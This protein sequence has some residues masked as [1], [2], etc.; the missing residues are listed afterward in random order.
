M[1]AA[2]CDVADA[3]FDARRGVLFF[4]FSARIS[5]DARVAASLLPRVFALRVTID[6]FPYARC[7]FSA[8][9]G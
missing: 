5:L 2:P 1:P 9:R 3:Y 6:I 4:F 8:M 7:L